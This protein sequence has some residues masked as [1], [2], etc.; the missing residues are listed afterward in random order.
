MLPKHHTKIQQWCL[1]YSINAFRELG[2][3]THSI[4]HTI[5]HS[6]IY[7]AKILKMNSKKKKCNSKNIVLRALSSSQ[8]LYETKCFPASSINIISIYRYCRV[9]LFVVHEFSWYQL[10]SAKCQA[11]NRAVLW[12]GYG[13]DGILEN[14]QVH[15]ARSSANGP[16]ENFHIF[17]AIMFVHLKYINVR[18]CACSLCV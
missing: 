17:I 18:C 3:R 4:M 2:E 9:T 12:V 10:P 16:Y 1:N 7:F 11:D 14:E 8:K 6:H 13:G 15:W 5:I